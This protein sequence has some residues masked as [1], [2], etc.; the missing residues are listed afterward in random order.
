MAL[1]APLPGAVAFDPEAGLP[2]IR[3][4][5]PEVY[6]GHS[7]IF[8]TARAADGVMYFGTYGAIV[9]FDGER[10]RQY[11]TT[12]TWTRALAIGPDGL[13]YVGGGGLLGR[14]E[15]SVENGELRFVSLAE[16]LPAALR[17]FASVW[18]A[19]SAG[20]SV[21]FAID[22]AVL[23]WRGGAFRT[24]PFP[25]QRPAIRSAGRNLFC[26]VGEQLLRWRDGDWR[27]FARDA[28]I[29]AVRRL[30]MLPADRGVI[31]A[32]D[33]GAIFSV[34][35]DGAL[36]P[37]P[38][39]ATALLER[40]GIRNG[41]RLAD[42]TYV[43]TTGGEGLVHLT[44]DGKPVRRLTAESG[45]ANA[46]TYGLGLGGDHELWVETAN[47]L[48]V[49]DPL[50]PWSFFDPRNGR[51]DTIGG[52]PVRF[53]GEIVLSMSDV[54]PRR[55]KP[56]A[57]GL[58]AAELVPFSARSAGRLSNGVIMHGALLNGGE[59]GVVRTDREFTLIHPT[60]G[61]IED[62]LA[63]QALPDV[64]AIGMLRGVEL[65]RVAPDLS[66][67]PHGPRA[68]LRAGNDQSRGDRRSHPL[69]RHHRGG[70]APAATRRRRHDR[71][72]DAI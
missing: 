18:S 27:P 63:M 22:G 28:R 68:G 17:N 33:N 66:V 2:M 4:F 71:E 62:I 39:G 47:G 36:A 12:G 23:E 31:A 32:L 58:G 35:D 41:L 53:Q 59:R 34:S 25:A 57:D 30:T 43:L 65:A 37:W 8:A 7:Q 3:N 69:G 52:E 61:Y 20:D 55:L 10:W 40:A 16:R 42:G 9:S 26:H 70:R 64:L 56:A 29:G 13:L 67:Q 6:R 60:V 24:W 46:A 1:A 5:P 50:A 45:L 11:A 15:P 14:L 21:L 38:T 19:G 44:A 54:P 72:P 48:S 51:P 49:F